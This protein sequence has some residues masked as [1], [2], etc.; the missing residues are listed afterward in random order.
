[1]LHGVARRWRFDL[2]TNAATTRA[3]LFVRERDCVLRYP[4]SRIYLQFDLGPDPRKDRSEITPLIWLP[5]AFYVGLRH[6]GYANWNWLEL[7][8]TYGGVNS[9][10]NYG[11]VRYRVVRFPTWL[12][13]LA[14]AVPTVCLWRRDR[15]YGKGRC[16]QCGY[17]LTGNVGGVCP[18]CGKQV[19]GPEAGESPSKP[20]A[21]A[22][23][24]SP[25]QRRRPQLDA[26][27]SRP[28]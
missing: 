21:D 19:D 6:I 17:D 28:G 7:P 16:R 3:A 22:P 10:P 12:L 20:H 13:L 8:N 24:P 1:M 18:E 2:E 25:P 4:E 15:P 23:D 11:Q 27:A 9:D 26:V 5:G 14:I